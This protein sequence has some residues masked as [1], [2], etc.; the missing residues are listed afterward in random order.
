VVAGYWDRPEATAETFE[1]GWL[2]TG[3]AGY[4]DKDGHLVVI[5]RVSDVMHTAK[6]EMFSPQFLENKLKFSPFIKEAVV[7]GDGRDYLTAFVNID[8]QTVGKWAE[9]HNLGYTTYMDLSQK[10]Q[11]AK[12]IQEEVAKVNA[13]IPEALRLKR[14]VLLYKLLDADDDELTRTGKVRRSFIIK[15]YQPIVDALY[16]PAGQ[17]K[18]ET[19]FK[20]QDGR[21]QKVE[22]DVR[23]L[24]AAGVRELV[25]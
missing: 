12:L 6:G 19:E 5:D 4:L 14:F 21:V 23:I 10:E 3:D 15:R 2:H 20:Y 13:G 7:F 11:V 9:D 1:N 18:V 8:P 17:V 16:S 24:E 22:T 25:S